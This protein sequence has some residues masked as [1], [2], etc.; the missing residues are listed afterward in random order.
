MNPIV[1]AATSGNDFDLRDL[2]KKRMSIYVGVTPNNLERMQ[3]ILNLFFQ[4]LIDLNTR[5]LPI[6][7]KSLKYTCLLLMDKLPALGKSTSFLKA[8]ATL[9]ATVCE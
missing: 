8:L 1:D 6:Q 4:Q 9:R 5:E 2:R 7:N 3:P